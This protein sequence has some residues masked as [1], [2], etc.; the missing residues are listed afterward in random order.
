MGKRSGAQR[1]SDAAASKPSADNASRSGEARG[2]AKSD[3]P[4]L[5]GAQEKKKSLYDVLNVPSDASTAEIKRA[6]RLLVLKVHPDKSAD[7]DATGKFQALQ[8]VYEVLVDDD[9]RRVYDETGRVL[10]DGEEDDVLG[11]LA[12]KSFEQLYEY[13]RAMYKKVQEEDIVAY[14]SVYRGSTEE[15]EDVKEHYERFDG[16]VSGILNYIPY[17]EEHDLQRLIEMI[18]ALLKANELEERSKYA[19]ARKTLLQRASKKAQISSAQVAEEAASTSSK[20]KTKTKKRAS[21]VRGAQHDTLADKILSK[22]NEREAQYD[23]LMD[24]LEKKYA[25]TAKPAR[26]K[27]KRV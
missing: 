25:A 6:Y 12:G 16:D 9:K 21:T 5:D 2:T 17:S 27:S 10:G 1:V 24:A 14:R 15:Q 18:D 7:P 26:K 13:Y 4:S 22:R 19:K 8:K 23:S 20:S 3:L 11:D